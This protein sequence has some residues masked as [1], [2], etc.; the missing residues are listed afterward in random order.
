MTIAAQ[1]L[2]EYLELTYPGIRIGRRNCRDT[3]SGKVSQHSAY[4]RGGF[5]S[6][7]LDIM[8]G[9]TGGVPWSRS[10]NVDLIQAVV[11]DVMANADAWSIRIVFWKVPDHF[12]HAHFD[13]WPTITMHM[14]CGGSVT[15]LWKL[16]DGT[17]VSTRDPEPENGRYDGGETMT[18]SDW[19][20]G[21][22]DL[23]T[24]DEIQDLYDAGYIEGNAAIV[25]AYWANLR[26]LGSVGRST[27]QRKEV[28]RFVQTTMTSAWLSAAN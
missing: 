21:W 23:V 13:F 12:G 8:G 20:N 3:A 25:V 18:F 11:D 22:F 15:P 24:D 19:A 26:D 5:D 4:E 2:R 10:E 6:N 16:S 1:Q 7:A 17:V 28:A 14:W 9:S 27:S